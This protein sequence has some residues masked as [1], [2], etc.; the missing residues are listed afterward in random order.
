MASRVAGTLGVVA[1]LGLVIRPFLPLGTANGHGVGT[2]AGVFGLLGWLPAVVVV[3]GAG[4]L[5]LTGRLPRFGLAVIGAA[6]AISVP[7]LLHSIWLAES[8]RTALDLPVGGQA[9]RGSAYSVGT[10]LVLE[11]VTAGLLVA[12]LLVVLAGWTGTVMDDGGGFDRRRPAFGVLGLFIGVIAAA[13]FSMAASSS[14]IGIA[15]AAVTGQVGLQRVAG[16]ILAA[17]IV[18]CCVLAP[19]LRPWLGAAGGLLGVAVML[20]GQAIENLI[21]VARS[22]DLHVDLGTVAQLVTPLFV[23]ALAVA[24]A[25]VRRSVQEPA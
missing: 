13:A 8:G 7:T 16:L 1:A 5:V 2:S 18:G 9:L 6:G 15:P 3:G 22:A 23:L 4:V 20:G 10:G 21:S 14:P 12:A 24:A 17:V 11:L 19:S 25:A